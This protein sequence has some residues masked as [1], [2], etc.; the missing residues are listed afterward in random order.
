MRIPLSWLSEHC[1][2]DLEPRALAERLSMTGTE[3]ERVTHRGVA[4]ADGFVVG[5]VLDAVQHPDAD[6]LRV[7]T[8]DI[9]TGEPQTIVCGAANV[10]AGQTVAVALPGAV[11]PD[12]TKLGKAK[13]RGVVSNGMILSETEMELGED[14]GGIAV[15]ADAVEPGAPLADVL[16][17]S[18]PVLELEITPNRPDC[19][20]VR[21]IAR[22][23][24]AI[25]GADLAAEPWAVDAEASGD[26]DVS[27]HASVVV[28][29]PDLC[30]R[31]TARAFED[32][33]IG[34]SPLWLK[35]RLLA[36]GQRPINNVVDITN[37]VML[38]TGQPLHSFDLDRV[39]GGEVI[40]RAAREGERMTTLD[41]VERT[42]DA[43]T[44]VVADRERPSGI[45]GIM[46]GQVSEVSETTTRVL[47]EAATWNGT[48]ILRTSNL[49]TLRS[50]ASTRFEKGLHPDLTMRAQAV[51]SRLLV[52]L[53]GARLVPGT[54]DVDAHDPAYEPFDIGVRTERIDALLGMEIPPVRVREYLDRLG[55][56][57]RDAEADDRIVVGVPPDR[58][59]DVTREVD[60]I[61]EVARVHGLDEHLPATLPPRGSA[62]GRLQGHQA[63]LRRLE[64]LLRDAG[65]DEAI[66]WS[67]VAP[68]RGG[69][70]GLDEIAAVTVHN[71]LSEDGSA[72]RTDLIG[73]LLGAARHNLARGAEGVGL[74][75]SGR[76]YL[77][78]RPPTGGGA[79]AG[80]FAGIRPAPIAEPHRLGCLVA[81]PLG[82][83]SWREPAKDADFYDAK[84]L[85]E[86]LCE[87]AGVEATYVPAQ[88]PF[89]H[90]ARSAG[91]LI[92]GTEVGWLGELHPSLAADLDVRSAVA[93]E[94]GAAPLLGVDGEGTA[95]FEDVTTHPAV[96]EDL[97]VVADRALPAARIRAEVLAAGGELLRKASV[98]DVYEGQQVP[99]GK[100]SLA[101]RLEFAAP[102]RTLTDAEVA[103][104]RDRIVEA[105]SS[106]GANLRG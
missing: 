68:D 70:P 45:A 57:A 99:E 9:G 84:G 7:C 54:I 14:S 65:L 93:F 31:F 81:G 2:P 49:L 6:R 90:P 41:D 50:E 89:L 18:E 66:T 63:R 79:P 96:G 92:D 34:P 97:A 73:G 74:F 64:D 105:L 42:L 100:R 26:D 37:Y 55:F 67:F 8:V 106:I 19:L 61:E 53:C 82:P 98:F 11:M 102:D 101:L 44:V 12:G 33:T 91:V 40:V 94:L 52:E 5:R 86:L 56:A 29:V 16:P 72:M 27:D 13:L 25:T 20:S 21:G 83:G 60:L 59:F 51:A 30:P 43:E 39:P 1:D 58:H 28:E 36:A 87:A 85:I 3:V 32:V 24:H 38:L 62:V 75:E 104:V 10:A 77:P 48:N 22:E 95:A 78:E 80:S 71:P 69:V 103:G 15:L 4:S 88:R 76:V 35:A 17:I 47:L 46:G 23:V